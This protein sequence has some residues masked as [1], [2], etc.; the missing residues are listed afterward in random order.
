MNYNN[1]PEPK[2]NIGEQIFFFLPPEYEYAQKFVFEGIIVDIQVS[3]TSL[4]HF[5]LEDYDHNEKIDDN[6]YNVFFKYLVADVKAIEENIKKKVGVSNNL[7]DDLNID[8]LL[9]D[10]NFK[11]IKSNLQKYDLTENL[12]EGS[13]LRPFHHVVRQYDI[14]KEL[15]TREMIKRKLGNHFDKIKRA[16]DKLQSLNHLPQ[17]KIDIDDIKR[18]SDNF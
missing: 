6:S 9:S 8:V 10:I 5:D 17:E 16:S 1:I 7:I 13:R 3:I 2:F 15:P 14:F 11:F 4:N 12:W 18:K